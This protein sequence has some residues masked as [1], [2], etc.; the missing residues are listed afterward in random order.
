MYLGGPEFLKGLDSNYTFGSNVTPVINVT[1]CGIPAPNVTWLLHTDYAGNASREE[2]DRYTYEYSMRLPKLTQKTCGRQLVL[3][4]SGY[5]MTERT[6]TV[7][8][9]ECKYPH[10]SP[11]LY[12]DLLTFR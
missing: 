12:E 4:V 1:L 10:H 3:N 7:F 8:V 6:T 11:H 9:T 5:N 2:S